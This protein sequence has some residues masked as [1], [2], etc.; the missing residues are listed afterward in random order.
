MKKIIF[1]FIL[2]INALFAKNIVILEP[3]SI[4]ILFML[5]AQNN[6]AG[7]ATT[8]SN[9]IWP[10]EE[11]AKLPSIGTYIK[12]NLEKIVEIKPDLVLVS[13][14][15]SSIVPE[16][17]KFNI[18]HET[19]QAN[20]IEDIYKNITKIGEHV[21]KKDESQKIIDDFKA[22]LEALNFT[23]LKGKKAIFFYSTS[24]LL[25]FGKNTLPDDVFKIMELEN[26][27]AKLEGNNPIV[28]PEYLLEENPDFVL[29]VSKGSVDDFLKQYP[30]LKHTNAAKN[31]KI[32][33][34]ADHALLRGTP[35]IINEIE[36]IYNEFVK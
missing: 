28:S 17:D 2:C 18:K 21:D 4:E 13:F 34:I 26:I 22:R 5:K 20:S 25:S 14:H 31:G 6:I 10:Q 35:R 16:L 30:I 12:P 1:S 15:S 8:Q 29:V 27:A 23:K 33:I 11:V 36:K 32:F 7:I 24:N 3:S 19:I 9:N